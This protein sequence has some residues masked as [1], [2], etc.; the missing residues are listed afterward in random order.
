MDYNEGVDA[1][2]P[3]SFVISCTATPAEGELFTFDLITSQVTKP[4]IGSGTIGLTRVGSTLRTN[5]VIGTPQSGMST[6]SFTIE[7]FGNTT[8]LINISADDFVV[9]GTSS[10]P[11]IPVFTVER[12]DSDGD[13]IGSPLISSFDVI[14]S[15]NASYNDF[16]EGRVQIAATSSGTIGGQFV[17][18][19]VNN[20]LYKYSS[21]STFGTETG[22]NSLIGETPAG[23]V[24]GQ[25]AKDGTHSLQWT[26]KSGTTGIPFLSYIEYDSTLDI[27]HLRT[28]DKDTLQDT[29]DT[30]EVLLNIS[31]YSTNELRTFYNQ[32]DFDT[33]YFVET[34]L[35]LNSFNLDDGISAFLAVNAVDVTLAA[36]TETSTTV[37]ADV[38]NAWGE[39][40][41]GKTVTW[42][43]STGDGAVAPSSS[44]TGTPTAGR[45]VTTFTVG[46]T[47]GVSTITASVTDT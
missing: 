29:T 38:I 27:I 32:N 30:R 37:N 16:L 33:L 15:P 22:S 12:R 26:H 36:G 42:S 10:F 6:D 9:S 17:Y 41:D 46:S 5:K 25:I 31:G 35:D 20:V 19:K 14:G 28:I 24:T 44:S 18:I 8:S 21:T 2:T 23:P 3:I 43:V 13:V 11:D 4:L 34:D 39:T 47:V 40:L 45:A 7:L 1:T